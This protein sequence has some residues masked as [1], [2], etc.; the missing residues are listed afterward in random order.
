M[1]HAQDLR[2]FKKGVT[3]VK[4]WA[5]RESRDMMCQFLPAVIDAQAPL[6]FIE[7]I[8]AL[9]DFS[10]IAHGMQLTDDDLDMMDRAL[11]AFHKAKYV[12][13][14]LEMIP[15]RKSFDRIAKLHMLGHYTHDIR[16]LGT[17]DGYSTETP[18]HLHI[19]YVKM[20]WH[21]SNRRN[22][23]PQMVGHVT[24]LEVIRTQRTY[25]DEFYGE[26]PEADN[27]ETDLYSEDED[28]TK[29]V[30]DGADDISKY[31]CDK[32]GDEETMEVESEIF[33]VGSWGAAS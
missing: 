22:P 10:Y 13:L 6:E 8:R 32:D 18:E 12:L 19:V 5:G 27:E 17:P 15:W 23:L 14:K 11:V 9:L 3:T 25:I 4:T 33:T 29:S 26:R 2:H 16:E 31:G 21:A 1:P 28:E 30:E 24:R 7:F 20:P